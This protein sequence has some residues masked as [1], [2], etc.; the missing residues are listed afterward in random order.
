[1]LVNKFRESL[2]PIGGDVEVFEEGEFFLC[3]VAHK[4]FTTEGTEENPGL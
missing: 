4:K 2:A 1:M 3:F